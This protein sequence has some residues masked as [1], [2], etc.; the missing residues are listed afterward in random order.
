MIQVRIC[1]GP[2]NVIG[3]GNNVA[4]A[5]SVSISDSASGLGIYH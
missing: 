3:A 2:V 5:G 1:F 4:P